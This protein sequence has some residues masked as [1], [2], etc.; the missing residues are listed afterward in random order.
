MKRATLCYIWKTGETG[1]EYLMLYRNK[2]ENDPNERKWIGVGGQFESGE[3]PDECMLREVREET[4]LAL[5]SYHFCGIIHFVSDTWED[6]DM[7]LYRAEDSGDGADLSC[8]E[9]ELR[10][11]RE[12][13]LWELPMWEGDRLFLRPLLEGAENINMT[14]RYEGDELVDYTPHLNSL[15]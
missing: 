4:G 12:D 14:L 3:T 5:T 13:A 1:R 11:I 7:Y 6:E 8:D 2:K 15:L 10:W 9:G